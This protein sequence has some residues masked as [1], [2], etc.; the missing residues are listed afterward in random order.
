[1]LRACS[2]GGR[3][4]Y[5]TLRLYL[6]LSVLFIPNWNYKL[7]KAVILYFFNVLINS[8]SSRFSIHFYSIHFCRKRQIMI[9]IDGF[10]MSQS[11]TRSAVFI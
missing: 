11:F 7:W 5:L 10:E 1:M 9:T 3:V 2:A 8:F 4:E 6:L